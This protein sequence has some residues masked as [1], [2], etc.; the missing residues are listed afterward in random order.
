M[1]GR[2]LNNLSKYLSSVSI[3][4]PAKATLHKG[5]YKQVKMSVPP[6]PGIYAIFRTNG[7]C[8]YVGSSINSMKGRLLTHY[9]KDA[10]QNYRGLLGELKDHTR[11]RYWYWPIRKPSSWGSQR[12]K[13]LIIGLEA[14]CSAAWNPNVV[15]LKF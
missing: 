10:K 6:E 11:F 5:G 7:D 13:C 4:R 14:A 8:F 2:A 1:G 12:F 15:S 3:P 9:G